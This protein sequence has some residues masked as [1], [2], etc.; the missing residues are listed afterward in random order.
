M[1]LHNSI[2]TFLTLFSLIVFGACEPVSQNVNKEGED[3]LKTHEL[4]VPLPSIKTAFQDTIYVPIY[5]DIYSESKN[6]RFLLTATL[7]IRNTSMSDSIFL[8]EI[9]YYDT[10]GNMV[11]KYND[12]TLF[13][14]PLESIDY[15][16]DEDDKSGG[17][18]ANFIIIWSAK[19]SNVKPIFE[20]VMISTKGQQGISFTSTGISIS[21][22]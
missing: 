2:Y 4:E 14:K 13:L 20:A 7:S 9:D 3:I 5:S 15:V 22:R 18:G 6:G 16:V 21:R 8:E 10:A 11:R 17:S 19:N 1:K 12:K